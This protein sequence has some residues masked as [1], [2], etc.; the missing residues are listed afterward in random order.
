MKV[1]LMVISYP[2]VLNSAARLFRELAVGLSKGGHQVTVLTTYPERYLALEEGQ[3]RIPIKESQ[4]GVEVHRLSP[5][6]FPK[7]V[8]FLRGIEH[9]AYGIQYYW[10]G[11]HLNH[12]DVV[13]AYSPPL[14]LGF[15]AI[16]LARK[17]KAVSIV[18]VQDLY[19]KSAVDLGL[20]RNPMLIRLGLWMERWVYKNADAIVVHSNGNRA[21]VISQGGLPDR[22]WV[23]PN[24]VDLDKY[25]PGPK[26]NEF[27]RK[28]ATDSDF[29]VS[30]AGVMGF[31]Q[32]VEDI[33]EAARIVNK[34]MPE[35]LFLLAGDGVMLPRHKELVTRLGINNVRFLPHLP[36]EEYVALLQA[37]DVCL[38]TL[39]RQILTPVVPGK[40]PCIMGVGRP[41]ICSTPPCSDARSLVEETDCGVWVPAGSPQALA[42]AILD[43]RS[44]PQRRQQMGVNARRYAEANFERERC[45]AHYERLISSLMEKK[46]GR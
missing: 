6:R 29:I 41:V 45:L 21:Y 18:N 7:H 19:P 33:I 20:L 27:R 23:I 35:I 22:T 31:A 3:R 46:R 39:H 16:H 26:D 37:S 1:L 13:I 28:F 9:V 15:A 2:P 12:Q 38:V 42:K 32:G 10:K 34:E 4:D 43:L 5:L 30:Y 25:K 17:W 36:E 24:W 8:P 11:R 40:L 14:P 44:Q